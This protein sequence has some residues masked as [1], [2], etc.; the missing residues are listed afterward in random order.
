MKE[1]HITTD[2][3]LLHQAM[4]LLGII[5]T[6]GAAKFFLLSHDVFVNNEKEEKRGRKLYPGDVFSIGK[7]DF[8]IVK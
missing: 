8:K 2:Y 6:G 3:I 1:L 4:K 5:P 7:L